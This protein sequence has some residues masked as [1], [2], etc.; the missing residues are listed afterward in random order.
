M[1]SVTAGLNAASLQVPMSSVTVGL[2]VC[3]VTVGPDVHSVTAGNNH[4]VG[5]RC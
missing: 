3:S 2:N 5:S 4:K 1:S